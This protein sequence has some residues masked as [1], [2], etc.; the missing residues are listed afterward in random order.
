MT[1][2][3][4]EAYLLSVVDQHLQLITLFGQTSCRT[5]EHSYTVIELVFLSILC[6]NFVYLESTK[7]RTL[8]LQKNFTG[9]RDAHFQGLEYQ[10]SAQLIIVDDIITKNAW[11]LGSRCLL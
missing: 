6:F 10:F 8:G 9:Q 5:V 3:D 2:F 7:S 4:S 11:K 1:V